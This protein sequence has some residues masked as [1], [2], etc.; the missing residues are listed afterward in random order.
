MFLVNGGRAGKSDGW[1]D[2]R[3]AGANTMKVTLMVTSGPISGLL[4]NH[5][6][7]LRTK[8]IE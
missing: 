7:S 1:I 5:Y 4:G 3:H 6:S 2:A 8:Q